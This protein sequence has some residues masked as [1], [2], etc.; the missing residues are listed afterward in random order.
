MNS[1]V[2][3]SEQELSQDGSSGNDSIENSLSSS[4]GND[5]SNQDELSDNTKV[6]LQ[7]N[8]DSLD[9]AND[10]GSTTPEPNIKVLDTESRLQQLEK[11]HETLN[12][13]LIHI[14]EPT[15]LRRI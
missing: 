1:D 2:P 3:S 12:L 10:Q 9:P 14:S 15:R 7:L 11:E 8:D 13:S 6:D 4:T 5:S